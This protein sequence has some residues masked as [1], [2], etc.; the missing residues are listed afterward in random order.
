[1]SGTAPDLDRLRVQVAYLRRIG[2][3]TL[4]DGLEALI[5]HYV[6]DGHVH[7]CSCGVTWDEEL[8]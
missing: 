2:R 3:G 7:R 8:P 6:G 1:M 4:A 5:T